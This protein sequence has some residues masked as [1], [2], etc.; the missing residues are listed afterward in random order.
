MHDFIRYRG[1]ELLLDDSDPGA[2]LAEYL[3]H[4]SCIE[5]ENLRVEFE[6][7]VATVRGQCAS[8][9]QR[10]IAIFVV[11]NVVGVHRVVDAMEALSGGD[12]ACDAAG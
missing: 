12:E 1:R 6:D 3:H 2:S 8:A 9:E 5:I 11:G 10:E 7:G 4:H